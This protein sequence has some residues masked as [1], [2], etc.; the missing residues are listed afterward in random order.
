MNET[1]IID[2]YANEISRIRFINLI[3]EFTLILRKYKKNNSKKIVVW[4]GNTVQNVVIIFTVMFNGLIPILVS[5][6]M[7]YNKVCEIKKKCEAEYIISDKDRDIVDKSFIVYNHKISNKINIESRFYGCI[8]NSFKDN[9]CLTNL[10]D[11]NLD[12]TCLIIPTSGTT[13]TKKIVML[14]YKNIINSIKGTINN[15]YLNEN[16]AQLIIFPINTISGLVC[17]LFS[18]IF[19]GGKVALY[20][21]FFTVHSMIKFINSIDI[22]YL[23]LTPSVLNLVNVKDKNTKKAF[24]KISYIVI[25]GE[26]IYKDSWLKISSKFP[27]ITI[28]PSYGLTEL[29]GSVSNYKAEDWKGDDYVGKIFDFVDVRVIDNNGDF[30]GDNIIGEIVLSGPT[31]MKGY[32]DSVETKKT[33]INNKYIKTG[34][35][36]YINSNDLYVTGRLKNIAIING[37]NV[38]LDAVEKVLRSHNNINNVRVYSKKNE[39]TG[40]SLVADIELKKAV[41]SNKQEI[42]KFCIDHLEKYMIPKEINFINKIELNGSLKLSR[43]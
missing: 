26:K 8:I 36:G 21:K 12:E 27:D 6:E 16:T 38:S 13:S 3:N 14:S 39:V 9:L 29:S 42:Y 25:C 1:I 24:S 7:T 19:A 33:L 4:G 18:V 17:Q 30:V 5:D 10:V 41:S 28:L 2:T 34:D 23:T 37:R 15:F 40:E 32:Y 31:V 35:M 22:N 20:D 43:R 11:K